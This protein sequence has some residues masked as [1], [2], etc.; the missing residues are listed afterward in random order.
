MHICVSIVTKN[1]LSYTSNNWNCSQ[2]VDLLFLLIIAF[3]T[4][5][6]FLCPFLHSSYS[7]VNNELGFLESF[8]IIINYSYKEMEFYSIT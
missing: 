2:N 7:I 5:L 6:T 8:L 4:Q 3:K 1:K